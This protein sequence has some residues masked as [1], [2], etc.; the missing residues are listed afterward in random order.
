MPI[1][2]NYFVGGQCPL[3]EALQA[4]VP[5]I[6]CLWCSFFICQMRTSAETLFFQPSSSQ[7]PILL[8]LVKLMS[9]SRVINASTTRY[10]SLY[11]HYLILKSSFPPHKHR[12]ASAW[13]YI[14][15]LASSLRLF[16]ECSSSSSE[17]MLAR[18]PSS[19]SL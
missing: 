19:S 10:I 3:C 11:P 14:T 6:S 15:L 8:N 7:M 12:G 17:G 13:D 4:L 18:S 1:L 9:C 5:V 2:I 16:T